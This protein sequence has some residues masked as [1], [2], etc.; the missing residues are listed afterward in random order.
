M[1]TKYIKYATAVILSMTSLGAAAQTSKSAYF[2]DGYTFK[3]QLNPAFEGE[4]N[5]VSIPVLGNLNVGTHG[6][7]GMGTFL[8]PYN[9]GL[10]TFMNGSVTADEFL[11]GLKERNRFGFN[12]DMTILSAGIKAWG[13]FNTFE[14]GLKSYTSVN[15]PYDLFDFMKTGMA[16]GNRTYTLTDMGVNSQ[17]YVEVALGH[18][19]KI[20]DNLQVGAKMKVLLGGA[21]ADFNMERMDITLNENQWVINANGEVNAALKG[22]KLPTKEETGNNKT[23]EENDQIDWNGIEF[24]SP[25]LSGVGFALDLG[26]SYKVMDNITVSAAVNDLGF[27]NWTNNTYAKTNNEEWTFDGFENIATNDDIE[28]NPNSLDNQLEQLGDELSSFTN[29]HRVSE[30]TTLNEMLAATLNVGV[31]YKVHGYEKL[32]IGL[33]SH[34]RFRGQYTYAEGRLSANYSPASWFQFGVNGSVSNLGAAWGWMINFHPR[35]FN[36]FIGMDQVPTKLSKQFVPVNRMNANLT[37]GF[38]VT[39]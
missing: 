29:L 27:I 20:N 5:Y 37:L 25:G 32:A 1:K 7:V 3:H 15:L 12:L 28:N 17:T 35:G 21:Y 22:L 38:N 23:P 19:R 11:G 16:N 31:E 10:T 6:N 34:T 13:G 33:L 2:L 36:F 24:E 39:Y 14:I 4:H 9:D 18:A 30:N 26:A 8:Y